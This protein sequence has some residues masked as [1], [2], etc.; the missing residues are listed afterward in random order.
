[1]GQGRKKTFFMGVVLNGRL[2]TVS[3]VVSDTLYKKCI[4]I[5]EKGTGGILDY[6]ISSFC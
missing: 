3:I 1:M 4:T 6:I 5:Y 2:Q